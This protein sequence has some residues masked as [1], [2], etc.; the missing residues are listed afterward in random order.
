LRRLPCRRSSHLA[1]FGAVIPLAAIRSK[2]RVGNRPLPT[3]RRHFIGTIVTL[4]LMTALS[5]LAARAQRI[6]LFAARLPNPGGVVAG[7]VMLT[8]AIAFMRPRWRKAVERRTRIVQLFMPRDRTERLLWVL[9]AASAGFGEEIT[10]RGVQP[11]L[12]A[13]L[14]SHPVVAAA[15]VAVTFGVGHM[16][17]GW[18]SAAIIV[19]VAASFQTVVWLSGSLYVAMAVHVIYDVVAGVTYG[20]LGEKLGYPMEPDAITAAAGA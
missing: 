16:I 14:I 17:Q 12:L 1:F 20:R 13:M 9:V 15:A 5:L 6:D 4:W 7:A 10:W 18:R 8:V 19:V 11:T 3:R 2:K